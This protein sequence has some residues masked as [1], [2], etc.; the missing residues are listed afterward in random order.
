MKLY[1]FGLT[2]SEKFFFGIT[3]LRSKTNVK[4]LIGAFTPIVKDQ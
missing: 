1:V 4:V 3:R 2:K